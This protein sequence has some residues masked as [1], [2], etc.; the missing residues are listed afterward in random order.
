MIVAQNFAHIENVF[1]L[2]SAFVNLARIVIPIFLLDSEHDERCRRL[3]TR[4]PPSRS[5]Q[6][7]RSRVILVLG[8]W[9]LRDV[10]VDLGPCC[11]CFSKR[12]EPVECGSRLLRT[13]G[14]SEHALI[15]VGTLSHRELLALV[16]VVELGSIQSHL[17]GH[18]RL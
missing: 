2:K 17:D 9:N 8:I 13:S 14:S 11:F 16:A 1:H 3:D 6:A 5:A 7:S 12:S 15:T 18:G 10:E 4:T